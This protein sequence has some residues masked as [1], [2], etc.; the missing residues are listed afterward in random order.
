MATQ[1]IARINSN[2]VVVAGNN[3]SCTFVPPNAYN[4]TFTSGMFQAPPVVIAT[5]D[6]T[7]LGPNYAASVSVGNTTQNGCSLYTGNLIG[8]AIQTGINLLVT[9]PI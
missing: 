5:S 6:T 4:V 2:G 8:Q 3:I 9:A 7:P 1:I